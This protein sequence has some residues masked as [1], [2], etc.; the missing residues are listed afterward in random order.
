MTVA[1]W[2]NGFVARAAAGAAIVFAVAVGVG[3]IGCGGRARDASSRGAAES[4]APVCAE[5]FSER[6]EVPPM[7]IGATPPENTAPIE[8]IEAFEDPAGTGSGASLDGSGS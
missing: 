8:A 2:R 3:V 6:W 1:R 4:L 7:G 5:C